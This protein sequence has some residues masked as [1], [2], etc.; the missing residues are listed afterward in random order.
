MSSIFLLVKKDSVGSFDTLYEPQNECTPYNL[1]VEKG[2]DEFSVVIKWKTTGKCSGFVQYGI[3]RNELDRVGFDVEG[4][5]KISEH[6]VVLQKL[7][8]KSRYYFLI[9]SESKGYGNN[10][11]ALEFMISEM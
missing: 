7:L 9:N 6:Q 5:L 10:G 3:D 4:N 1:F 2:E 8:T 11:V